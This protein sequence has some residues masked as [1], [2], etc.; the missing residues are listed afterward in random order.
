VFHTAFH[1]QSFAELVEGHLCRRPPI[2]VRIAP[3]IAPHLSGVFTMD[4]PPARVMP[5]RVVAQ[6]FE[7]SSRH[8]RALETPLLLPSKPRCSCP[9]NNTSPAL[10]TPLL[11]PS[12]H[13]CSFLRNTRYPISGM[14]FGQNSHKEGIKPTNRVAISHIGNGFWANFAQ[15]RNK[16]YQPSVDIPFWECI[17]GKFL[18]KKA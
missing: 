1:A 2:A 17:M 12:K 4:I 13:H 9:R 16:A 7:P 3:T 14:D 11:V 10:E 8:C 15:R 5:Q 18:I 6:P